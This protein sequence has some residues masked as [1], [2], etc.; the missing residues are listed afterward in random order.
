VHEISGFRGLTK[1][2]EALLMVG[3]IAALAVAMWS[4]SNF[5]SDILRAIPRETKTSY[6]I[7]ELR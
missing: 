6:E 1:A 2:P 5:D 7:R 3:A 4:Y